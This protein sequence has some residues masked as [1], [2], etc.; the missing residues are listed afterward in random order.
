MAGGGVINEM[1]TIEYKL[2]KGQNGLSTSEA[3]LLKDKWGPNRLPVSVWK[4]YLR[5][6]W[7]FLSEPMLLLLIAA[8]TLYFILGQKTE[9][10]I[11]LVAIGL[12][13]LISVITEG[14]SKKAVKQLEKLTT[15]QILAWRDGELMPVNIYD[16][17][18][19]DIIFLREGDRVPADGILLSANDFSVNEA[20]LSGESLPLFKYNSDALS[21]QIWQGTEV[22]SG[23]AVMEVKATG[24]HTRLAALGHRLEELDTQPSP[25]KIKLDRFVRKMAITGIVAFFLVM[26]LNYLQVG[27]WYRSILLALTLAMSIIPEE[28][29]VAFSSFMALGSLRLA[30]KGIIVRDPKTVESLGQADVI[31]LDKTGTIT[32]NRLD[33]AAVYIHELNKTISSEALKT[34]LDARNII[35][36]ACLASEIN[37]SDPLEKA[38]WK[39]A[40]VDFSAQYLLEGEY[41]LAGKPPLM[42]HLHRRTGF[43][44]VAA[45]GAFERVIEI[46]HL[47]SRQKES[48]LRI[49]NLIASQGK[50]ILA[51]A[52]AR[53]DDGLPMPTEQDDYNWSFLGLLAFYDTPK[54]N[55]SQSIAA[56]Y[57]SG[58]EVKMI[59]GDNPETASYVASV[60]GIKNP[61]NFITGQELV[62]LPEKDLDAAVNR[63]YVMARMFPEA[64]L[65]VIESLK[66]QGKTVAM[67]G[68]GVND[69]LALKSAHIGITMGKE[70]NDLTKAVASLI[71]SDDKIQ[72]INEAIYEGK[73]IGQNLRMA[74]RYI[75]SIHIPIIATV[76]V[77]L[78]LKWNCTNLF[79]PIHVIFLEIIMGPTCSIFFENEPY[80]PHSAS[81]RSS[82]DFFS[83]T[84]LYMSILQGIFISIAVLLIYWL[85]MNSS[86]DIILTRTKV[87]MV[88]L[89]SNL[90]LT[91]TNR[92]P[93]EPFYRTIVYR[94]FLFPIVMLSSI[95]F[96]LLILFVP[97]IQQIFQ[98]GYLD[99]KQ[100][101]VCF[102]FA[103]AG[104][105]W[106]EGWK[107]MKKSD[108]EK[109][110]SQF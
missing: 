83:G 20:M 64:K 101:S 42:T 60:V 105:W 73:R 77:P 55:A 61:E 21:S 95:I 98:V 99:S 71:I 96:I 70:G 41:P 15:G 78:V 72:K 93:N 45:K 82:R 34:D 9:G 33:L 39:Y 109:L 35:E 81:Y 107:I 103:L 2:P 36:W 26:V 12:I 76:V 19:Q 50:R 86:E 87:F 58:A 106:I 32:T 63:F 22:V 51:I 97:S 102:L 43:R 91:I 40:K 29:P 108:V 52:K 3:K 25:L 37:P 62:A 11:M 94:N 75:I 49:H 110:M 84:E 56:M 6:I 8:T 65:K 92:S 80:K 57:A 1:N 17:V 28:I 7:H 89:F 23:R 14:R 54:P 100:I 88:L 5:Q 47:D 4:N 44:D 10:Q 27:D 48:L 68:D 16:L 90:L 46:C 69:G 18:P 67:T 53:L 30:K 13:T 59:T 38:I 24:G 85:S 79:T 74:I 104:T 31:C 66:R